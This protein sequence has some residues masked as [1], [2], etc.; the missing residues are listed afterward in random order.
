MAKAKRYADGDVVEGQNANIGDDTRARAM[1]WLKKQQEGGSEEEAPAK[2]AV[3][4]SAPAAKPAE[5]PAAKSTARAGTPDDIPSSAPRGWTGGKGER[6]TGSELSRNVENT[7][8]ALGPNAPRRMLGLASIPAEMRAGRAAQQAYNNR[9]A[10]RRAE[11]GLSSDEAKAVM[12]RRALSEADTTG[13][14]VGYKKGGSVSK[15]SSRADGCAQRGK[16]RGRVL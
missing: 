1:A 14:A 5:K 9:A 13:G 3:R 15:A 11:E 10:M 16:T 4:R 8:N 6:V 12:R 2:P 7:L